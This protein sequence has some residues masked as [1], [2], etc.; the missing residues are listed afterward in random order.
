MPHFAPGNID[1][2]LRFATAGAVSLQVLAAPLTTRAT[3]LS[4]W[5]RKDRSGDLPVSTSLKATGAQ[6]R[7]PAITRSRTL[8]M[9]DADERD[10][11]R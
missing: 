9:L 1:A 6:L 8:A 3:W 5:L 10:R 11:P 2:T 7:K 4:T